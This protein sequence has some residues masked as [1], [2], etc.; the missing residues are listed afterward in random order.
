MS[1]ILSTFLL[2]MLNTQPTWNL[3]RQKCLQ[4]YFSSK[5]GLKKQHHFALPQEYDMWDKN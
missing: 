1:A 2:E 3:R 4:E 5:P